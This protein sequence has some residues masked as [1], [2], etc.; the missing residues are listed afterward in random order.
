[1]KTEQQGGSNLPKNKVINTPISKPEKYGILIGNT[2][3]QTEEKVKVRSAYEDLG[4]ETN[5]NNKTKATNF[6]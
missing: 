4:T 1:V 2:N 6:K 3:R 5:P